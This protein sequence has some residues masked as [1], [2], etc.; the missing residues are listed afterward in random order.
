[1]R[2]LLITLFVV[3]VLLVGAD[4]AAAYVADRG[5][6]QAVQTSAELDETPTVNIHGFPLL[7]Q[8]LRGR[9][10]LVDGTA[11]NLKSED[12]LTI[13]E[14]KLKLVGV[15]L[16]LRDLVGGQVTKL[17]VDSASA[18]GLVTYDSLNE[19]ARARNTIPDLTLEFGPGKGGRIAVK[20]VYSGLIRATLSGEAAV[21][22]R[23][24]QL[25]V[26]PEA[27]T[28]R[29]V[30]SI[31]SASLLDFLASRY[32]L[33]PFPFGFEAQEVTVGKTGV[34]VRADAKDAVLQAQ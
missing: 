13:D 4:R 26:R 29:G 2:G 27:S 17:P 8:A 10:E 24:G 25:V 33:P 22:V 28:L 18:V 11:T 14:L 30:P 19:A 7:T 21:A 15:E 16:P 1:M 23:D 20:G 31:L 9:Y 5:V 12:G 3:L 34:S 32:E 6:A